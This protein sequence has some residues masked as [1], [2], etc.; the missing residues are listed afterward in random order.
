MNGKIL[1]TKKAIEVGKKLRQQ[2]KKIVLAGGCFDILHIGH[3]SYLEKSKAQGDSLFILLESDEKIRKTKGKNRPI[4][5]QE[6]RAEVLAKL[7]MIDYIVT[8]KGVLT[9]EDYDKLILAIKPAIIATTKA[10]PYRMHKERQ[11]TLSGARVV[12]VTEVIQTN[13]TTKIAKLLR[14]EL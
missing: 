5:T 2:G 11:A 12:D 8:L 6:D 4:N 13:S 3:I 1:T 9:N 14:K 7:Q 10:D